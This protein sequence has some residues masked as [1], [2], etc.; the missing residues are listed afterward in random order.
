MSFFSLFFVSFSVFVF[1]F[2]QHQ[3]QQ[4]E[5]KTKTLS[6]FFLQFFAVCHK[7]QVYDRAVSQVPIQSVWNIPEIS[8]DLRQY[9][10]IAVFLKL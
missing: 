10:L 7:C 3:K 4:H 6:S 9:E 2:L 5:S 8:R 1:F